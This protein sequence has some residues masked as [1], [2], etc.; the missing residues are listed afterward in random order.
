[1]FDCAT[2]GNRAL[3]IIIEMEVAAVLWTINDVCVCTAA[4]SEILLL[5]DWVFMNS[6]VL[7]RRRHTKMSSIMISATGARVCV[8]VMFSCFQAARRGGI[9]ITLKHTQCCAHNFQTTTERAT[10]RHVIQLCVCFVG[11]GGDCYHTMHNS[12][13]HNHLSSALS[14]SAPGSKFMLSARG[15]QK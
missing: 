6:S 2:P 10:Q 5:D 13:A 11:R 4:A 3:L 9:Q 14:L 8:Y 1:M 7:R 15:P 12:H